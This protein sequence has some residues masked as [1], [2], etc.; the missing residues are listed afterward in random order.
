MSHRWILCWLL[1][2]LVTFPALAQSVISAHSGLIHFVDGSVFL[3]DERVE[4]KTGKFDQMKNGSELR[5]QDGRAEVLLT[6]ATFL[7]VG[8][9]SAIRMISNQLDDTRVE[10]LSGAAVLDQGPDTLANTSVVILYNLDQVRIKKPGQYRFDSEPP[11][12]KV[13]SGNAEVTADGKSIEAGAGYVVAFQ[14]N[15]VARKLLNDPSSNS[16]GDDLDRWS[17]QRDSS[18]AANNLDASTTS[19]L[20]GVIDGWQNNPDAVLQSLGIPPYIPGMSSV[21]PPMGYGSGLYGSGL[22]G[23]GLYDSGLYGYPLYG[24]YLFGSALYGPG[25]SPYSLWGMGAFSPLYL[26]RTSPYRSPYSTYPYRGLSTLPGGR[27][28]Y[29]SIRSFSPVRPAIGVG[30]GRPGMG[31]VHGGHR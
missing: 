7:R 22:Y 10:L 24:S 31:A 9:N 28:G 18:V 30:I 13:E 2:P 4:Q 16:S 21:L 17:A 12:V 26:Y 19:D 5:T 29:G 15:L 3:D 6:P 1:T 14:G 23:S 20:S 27:A 8:P 11:Q 25:L